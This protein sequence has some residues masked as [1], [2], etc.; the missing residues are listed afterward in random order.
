MTRF[1]GVIQC[2][3]VKPP[4]ITVIQDGPYYQERWTPMDWCPLQ[5]QFSHVRMMNILTRDMAGYMKRVAEQVPHLYRILSHDPITGPVADA[6][7]AAELQKVL[8]N[9]L[10]YIDDYGLE[11][12]CTTR[13][14]WEYRDDID[15]RND[16]EDYL[17]EYI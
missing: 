12:Y 4:Y 13:L 2:K 14:S 3:I 7:R 11:C 15:L 9:G 8:V 5:R 1:T 16:N 17:N 10:P 6:K